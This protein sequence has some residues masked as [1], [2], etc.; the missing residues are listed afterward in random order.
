MMT[1]PLLYS[2]KTWSNTET[3]NKKLSVWM[4]KAS[5]ELSGCRTWATWAISLQEEKQRRRAINSISMSEDGCSD[6][7]VLIFGYVAYTKQNKDHRRILWASINT[8]PP[9]DWRRIGYFI[10]RLYTNL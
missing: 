3:P 9:N 1:V 4:C 6:W 8:T 2:S 5:G 10:N 7:V